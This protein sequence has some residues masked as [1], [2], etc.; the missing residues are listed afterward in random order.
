MGWG[1]GTTDTACCETEGGQKVCTKKQADHI[2]IGYCPNECVGYPAGPPGTC[3]LAELGASCTKTEECEGWGT[4]TTTDKKGNIVSRVVCCTANGKDLP[5]GQEGICTA[6]C[7]NSGVG[8]CP[9]DHGT[10]TCEASIGESCNVATDCEGWGSGTTTD[11]DGNTVRA[12]VCCTEDGKD[13]PS[14][15]CGKPR[16]SYA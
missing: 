3:D 13:N 16:P 6:P 4:G 7:L 10:L 12:V 11:S 14:N 9:S 15:E 2:G 8:Y 5:S 1:P